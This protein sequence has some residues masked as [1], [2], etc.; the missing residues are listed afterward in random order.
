[1]CV[2]VGYQLPLVS[3]PELELVPA[4]RQPPRGGR[5]ARSEWRW[6]GGREGGN[7]RERMGQSGWEGVGEQGRDGETKRASERVK[8]RQEG[9][10]CV[11]HTPCIL[12]TCLYPHIAHASIHPHSSSAD[13]KIKAVRTEAL[14]RSPLAGWLGEGARSG[15]LVPAR[16]QGELC[17]PVAAAAHGRPEVGRATPAVPGAENRHLLV[18]FVHRALHLDDAEMRRGLAPE[19]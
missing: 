3:D 5:V 19:T 8:I 18:H 14:S 10:Q 16:S 9:L 6:G 2:C 15:E 1:V 12:L 4:A 17:L 7:E 13:C 11:S